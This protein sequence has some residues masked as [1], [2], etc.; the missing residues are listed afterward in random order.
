MLKDVLAAIGNVERKISIGI[1]N[2]SGFKWEAPSH[3]FTSGTSDRNLP[4]HLNNGETKL[5]I[6]RAV[7]V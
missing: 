3:Y 6:Y 5:S 2:E 7:V 4:Y 1:D